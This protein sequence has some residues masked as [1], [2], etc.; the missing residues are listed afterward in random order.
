MLSVSF[1]LGLEVKAFDSYL[2]VLV[3]I[4]G[5]AP[6]IALYFREIGLCSLILPLVKYL[7]SLSSIISRQLCPDDTLTDD[8]ISSVFLSNL[9]ISH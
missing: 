1:I 9:S 3:S 6:Y 2:Q 5:S 7:L 8:T 4:L